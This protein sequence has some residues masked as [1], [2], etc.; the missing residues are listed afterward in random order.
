M[1]LDGFTAL[2]FVPSEPE[3]FA[4]IESTIL[5]CFLPPYSPIIELSRNT[6]YNIAYY[7]LANILYFSSKERKRIDRL[8]VWVIFSLGQFVFD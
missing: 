8:E 5:H 1:A 3:V 7:N 2:L 6:I 4:V